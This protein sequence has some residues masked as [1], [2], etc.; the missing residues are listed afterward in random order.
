MLGFR[1]LGKPIMGIGYNDGPGSQDKAQ[2]YAAIKTRGSRVGVAR[3]EHSKP[4]ESGGCA[5]T[6]PLDG[7]S[8]RD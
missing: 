2:K 1:G 5:N 3:V 6:A 7:D 8:H 4:E